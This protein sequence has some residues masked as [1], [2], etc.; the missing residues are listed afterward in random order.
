MSFIECCTESERVVTWVQKVVSTW[1]FTLVIVWP[2][3]SYAAHCPASPEIAPPLTSLGKSQIHIQSVVSTECISTFKPPWIRKIEW[4]HPRSGTVCINSYAHK[5]TFL[6]FSQ[7][8]SND[9]EVSSQSSRVRV[10]AGKLNKG[11]GEDWILKFVPLFSLFK[12][13]AIFWFCGLK[14]LSTNGKI[15][16]P[17]LNFFWV[18]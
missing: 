14:S 6:S 5:S 13:K 16:L 4:D 9:T 12:V 11:E 7:A 2:T 3:G 17:F 15:F 10:G 1:L 18:L 8:K